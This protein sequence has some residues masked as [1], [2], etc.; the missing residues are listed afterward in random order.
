MQPEQKMAVQTRDET[1]IQLSAQPTPAEMMQV[2]IKTGVTAENVAAFTELVKLSE[3]ME[4][5]KAKRDFTTAFAALQKDMPVIVAKTEIP[6][7]GRYEKFE[8]LMEVV[9]PLLTKHGFTISFSNDFREG[10]I[11]ETCHLKHLLSG[12]EE[13]NSYAVRVGGRADSE[14]QADLKAS[15]TAKRKALQHA[16][17]IVIRQD[18]LDEEHDASLEGDFVSPEQA[19]ELERRVALLNQPHDKFLKWLGAAKYSEIAASKYGM[20][21]DFLAKKECG[22]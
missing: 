18:I 6:N 3:H 4:D 20:A 2:M 7:R 14:T 21:N 22:R 16:L 13:T 11:I 19:D 10:R 1:G 5:R 17:N 9:Q 8:D 15:T 12:H